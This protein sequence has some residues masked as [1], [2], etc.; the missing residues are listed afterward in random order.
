MERKAEERGEKEREGEKQ[1]E[2]AITQ[3]YAAGG[4]GG[5]GGGNGG[6]GGSDGKETNMKEKWNEG[7]RQKA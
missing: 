6:G 5:G 3:A 2:G 7:T 4:G 1:R